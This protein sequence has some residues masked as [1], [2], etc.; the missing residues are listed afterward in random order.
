[1][2]SRLQSVMTVFVCL[3]VFRRIG[4]HIPCLLSS[5]LRLASGRKSHLRWKKKEGCKEA[6]KRRPANDIKWPTL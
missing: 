2:K 3:F 4:C 6:I 5:K 1:M